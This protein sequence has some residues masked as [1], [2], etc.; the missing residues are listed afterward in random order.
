M[1]NTGKVNFD[2]ANLTPQ[3]QAMA[4]QFQE[5][6]KIF[7]KYLVKVELRSSLAYKVSVSS[8]A[9]LGEVKDVIIQLLREKVNDFFL[10]SIATFIGY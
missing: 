8:E 7:D 1:G 6:H 2:D 4:R 3:E 5:N 9:Y 10:L